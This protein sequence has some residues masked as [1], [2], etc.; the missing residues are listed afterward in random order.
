MAIPKVHTEY[1]VLETF[2][3]PTNEEIDE[4]EN[5]AFA[6][7]SPGY[8]RSVHY[9]GKY[10]ST[11]ELIMRAKNRLAEQVQQYLNEGWKIS[12][13]LVVTFIRKYIYSNGNFD[14]ISYSQAIIK[15][16]DYEIYTERKNSEALAC[17]KE[18]QK[19]ADA[20]AKAKEEKERR[21]QLYE[22]QK[23]IDEENKPKYAELREKWNKERLA[24]IAQE[25]VDRSLNFQKELAVAINV[26]TDMENATNY[27]TLRFYEVNESF[28]NDC[29]IV[30]EIK[31]GDNYAI[32]NKGT[33]Y[34]QFPPTTKNYYKEGKSR[35][36]T[37]C[38]KC[39]SMLQGFIGL[40]DRSGWC[41]NGIVKEFSCPKGCYTYNCS[42]QNQIV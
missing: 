38:P 41:H 40:N 36:P 39:K 2:S 27:P 28:G 4:Y 10:P 7:E 22:D 25:E 32:A 31:N 34:Y 35:F 3:Y 24:K 33:N 8:Q 17:E 18:K 1:K 30:C 13:S 26:Q 11:E 16:G 42:S 5:S 20:L 6:H 21:R 29:K 12:G 15:E 37:S 14:K 23:R 19:A 9:R